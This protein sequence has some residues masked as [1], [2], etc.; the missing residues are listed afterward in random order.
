[1]QILHIGLAIL[2]MAIWGF[3][4]VVMK[5]CIEQIPPLLLTAARFLLLSIPAV[6]FIKKPKVPFK[7]VFWYGSFLFSIQF[8][9]LLLGMNAGVTA[10]VASILLQLQVFFTILFG[11]LFFHEKLHIWQ[12]LG[13]IVSFLGIAFILMNLGESVTFLGF[14]LVLAASI[15][16]AAGNAVSKKIGKVDMI[17]LVIWGSLVA[18]PP[19]LIASFFLNTPDEMIHFFA[20][21]SL[22]TWLGFIY[23]TFIA[24][25]V[26]Y[27]IW[28]FLLHHHPAGTIAPFTLLIPVFGILSSAVLLNEPLQPWKIISVLLV[29][30]GLGINLLGPRLMKRKR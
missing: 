6:F 1:M 28:S 22:I 29:F 18:W 11:I 12:V 4:M 8:A 20:Q 30:A 14:I 19:L 21:A 9:L 25:L 3:N 10:G 23:F 27:V 26:A 13:A 16:W 17:S 15:C 5:V 2:L 7:L 24:T